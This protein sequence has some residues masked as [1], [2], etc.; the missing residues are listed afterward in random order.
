MHLLPRMMGNPRQHPVSSPRQFLVWFKKNNNGERPVYTS[1]NSYVDFNDFEKPTEVKLS[2][3][4]F[5][6]DFDSENGK[7]FKNVVH[8]VRVVSE[9]LYDENIRH[10]IQFSGNKGYH[11]FMH[12]DGTKYEIDSKLSLKYKAIY[13][14]LKNELNLETLDIKCAE[15][16]RLSR[17]PFTIHNKT[18]SWALPIPR[19][20]KIPKSRDKLIDKGLDYFDYD[21][22]DFM[23]CERKPSIDNLLASW[24]I[25][26]SP[27]TDIDEK[28]YT[29]TRYEI[30]ED[31]FL[32]LAEEYFRPCVANAI[33]KRNPSH[34]AR[35]SAC[36]KV[37]KFYSLDKAIEFF[38]KLSEEAGWVDRANKKIR[39]YNIRH[40]YNRNYKLPKC[41][42][43]KMEGLCVGDECKFYN[44]GEDENG[45]QR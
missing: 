9:L 31:S 14:Y 8:D 30:P 35:L 11:I 19:G 27:D 36:I 21:D 7:T 16:K 18:K 17:M 41:N 24:D 42:R 2:N 29:T 23:R 5:D 40:I 34:F 43:L 38:D 32:K 26:V 12:M 1:H 20:E 4:F 25:D 28:Y 37:S 22:Y 3:M 15:P 10:V 13:S 39:D 45:K 6:F 33:F 44:G